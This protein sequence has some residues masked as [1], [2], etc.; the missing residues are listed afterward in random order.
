MFKRSRDIEEDLQLEMF[1]SHPVLFIIY[2]YSKIKNHNKI[3]LF[4]WLY[5]EKNWWKAMGI[6]T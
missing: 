6:T 1:C 3:T 4:L 2:K 5:Q